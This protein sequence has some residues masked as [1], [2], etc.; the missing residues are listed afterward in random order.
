MNPMQQTAFRSHLGFPKTTRINIQKS[1]ST[2]TGLIPAIGS[3]RPD[4]LADHQQQPTL[5]S[6]SPIQRNMTL[7][8]SYTTEG[9]S[10]GST[11]FLK[12]T[13]RFPLP[14]I[15]QEHLPRFCEYKNLQGSTTET[16]ILMP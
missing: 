9:L 16:R 1:S 14:L 11:A 10:I 13:T 12:L 6:R 3:L 8:L 7:P 15:L 2:Y 4:L 5:L